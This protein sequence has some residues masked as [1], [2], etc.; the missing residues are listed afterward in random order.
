ML[1]YWTR[2][3]SAPLRL[4]V[5][6]CACRGGNLERFVR[7]ILLAHLAQ[8]PGGRQGYAL[9]HALAE[10]H[11]LRPDPSGLYCALRDLEAEGMVE[12]R[13]DEGGEGPARRV[14]ALTPAGRDC[15][16]VWSA[17]LRAYAEEVRRV[18][19]FCGCVG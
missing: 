1:C 18:A 12:S 19:D 8:V 16:A 15:L 11:N 7:P 5:H 17:T 3:S 4:R 13:S 2:S 10:E 14:Y 9:L 6:E